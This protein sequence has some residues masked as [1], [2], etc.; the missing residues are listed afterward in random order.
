MPGEWL[1]QYCKFVARKN[2]YSNIATETKFRMPKEDNRNPEFGSKF[3]DEGGLSFCSQASIKK[4]SSKYRELYSESDAGSNSKAFRHT[5]IKPI[6]NNSIILK[7]TG[8]TVQ[9]QI[10]KANKYRSHTRFIKL[11]RGYKI[12][13]IESHQEYCDT[14][15][16]ALLVDCDCR[17]ANYAYVKLLDVEL[18]KY[19][20]KHPN[21]CKMIWAKVCQEFFEV[22]EK[23]KK[24]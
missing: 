16:R 19:E 7:F 1:C 3:T 5:R 15:V 4:I 21:D 20:Q 18:E 2:K 8:K 13:K 17:A 24:V 11:N 9:Q 6:W 14:L 22:S 23:R 10:R 12:K